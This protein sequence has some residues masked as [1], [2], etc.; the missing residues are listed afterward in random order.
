MEHGDKA[1]YRRPWFGCPCCPPN[2]MRML[3]SLGHY[4]VH[5]DVPGVQIHQY[6]TRYDTDAGAGPGRAHR[7]SVV[8]C[9]SR[10]RPRR[11]DFRPSADPPPAEPTTPP[12]RRT[13]VSLR[14]PAWCRD[15]RVRVNDQPTHLEPPIAATCRCG[16]AGTPATTSPCTWRCRPDLPVR[17]GASTR[18]AA[19]SRSNAVRSSTASRRPTYRPGSTRRARP[20]YDRTAARHR[21][22]RPARRHHHHPGDGPYQPEADRDGGRT[23]AGP[24]PHR[25]GRPSTITA[26]PY[27]TWD[28]RDRCVMRTWTPVDGQVD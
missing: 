22:T 7:L 24:P 20:R 15:W 26:I 9:D 27:H 23:K 10:D 16:G 12:R 25:R 28:N 13:R 18:S 14:L 4:V 11:P 5:D 8:R 19:A 21:P 6:A 3:T 1:P 17:T 2:L